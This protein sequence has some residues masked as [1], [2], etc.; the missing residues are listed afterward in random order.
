MRYVAKIGLILAGIL[1]AGHALIGCTSPRTR[2]TSQDVLS[3]AAS[4]A[5][6]II[7]RAQATALV[8]QAQAQATE[9]MVQ[10]SRSSQVSGP[11]PTTMVQ[12]PTLTQVNPSDPPI[13]DEAEATNTNQ[14]IQ[15]IGV[16]FAAEG[17]FIIVRFFAPPDEAEKWWQGSVSVTDE[18]NGNAY[19]EIPV[20]PKIGPLIGRP[21]RPGQ[22][23][24][25]MLVNVP[26][27]L[28]SGDT[29]TVVLGDY[30]FEHIP[31]E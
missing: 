8:L 2:A 13:V 14:D 9:M 26:P 3:Q 10:A 6:A 23:G 5:T 30:L 16:G 12:V 24:Y 21:K 18:S 1:T 25:V 29:V 31:V 19:D 22:T 27:G 15:I 7:Q 11:A 20:M 28:Q 4:E 17:S